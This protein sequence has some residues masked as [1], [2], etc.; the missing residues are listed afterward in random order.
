MTSC[1][2]RDQYDNLLEASG[3][4]GALI[5]QLPSRKY[6]IQKECYTFNAFSLSYY[7]LLIII[8]H[9]FKS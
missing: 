4:S 5:G 8:Q 1:L 6:L 9:P 3:G 7:G 2:K